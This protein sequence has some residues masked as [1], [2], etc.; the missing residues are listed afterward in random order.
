MKKQSTIEEHKNKEE[1]QILDDLGVKFFIS[2]EDSF[3][4]FNNPGLHAW[5]E[6][7]G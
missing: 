6:G 7:V 5:L 1:K 2:V 3:N 4:T